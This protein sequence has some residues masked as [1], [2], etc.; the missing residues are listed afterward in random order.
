MRVDGVGNVRT[1]L[2]RAHE[3]A[4]VETQNVL[5][6]A[7]TDLLEVTDWF[8]ADGMDHHTMF[9]RFG[10]LNRVMQ[11]VARRVAGVGKLPTHV[12]ESAPPIAREVDV[13]V[14]GGG[15]AGMTVAGDCARAGL[16]TMLVDE[17]ERLGGALAILPDGPRHESPRAALLDV[18][19]SLGTC[20]VRRGHAAVGV[21]DGLV[22]IV[23]SE[24][25]MTVRPRHL[26]IAMGAHE[27]AVA[28]PGNDKPGAI[29]LRAACEL[30]ARGVLCG[31]RIALV[32]D[33][34]ADPE[35]AAWGAAFAG[36]AREHGVDVLGPFG[37]AGVAKIGGRPSVRRI[38]TTDGE[39]HRCDAVVLGARPTAA[40]ELAVQA[41]AKVAMVDGAFRVIAS[42]DGA[43]EV[44]AVT[45]IGEAIGLRSTDW[46]R[47][48]AIARAAAL[49]IARSLGAT[50]Q[51]RVR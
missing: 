12:I 50:E 3:G 41:G 4:V 16:R 24:G 5:G 46:K 44:A 17:H 36:A 51:T 20:E 23:A 13:L 11:K 47:S 38:E 33:D 49:R 31:E 34:L 40:F 25:L 27:G 18:E 43:T 37:A 10:P 6:S 15:I 9:T 45:A 30:L 22:A 7:R 21:Y 42:D 28:L 2:A 8:F 32:L 29:G 39:E 35:L 48:A 19:E 26:V 1:C 14:V